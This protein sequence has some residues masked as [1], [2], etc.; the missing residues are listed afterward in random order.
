MVGCLRRWR[1]AHERRGPVSTCFLCVCVYVCV[2][3]CVAEV[4]KR[5]MKLG[6]EDGRKSG[7]RDR[8]A[9][10]GCVCVW[11]SKRRSSEGRTKTKSHFVGLTFWNIANG[12]LST[13]YPAQLGLLWPEPAL[14]HGGGGCDKWRNKI[15]QQRPFYTQP[16]NTLGP[17]RLKLRENGGKHVPSGR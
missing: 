9:V 2:T 5:R 10:C 12:K 8:P 3:E 4:K 7:V 15:D 14:F 11:V 17:F 1:L 6:A 13:F 16:G